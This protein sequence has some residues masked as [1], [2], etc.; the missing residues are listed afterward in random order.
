MTQTPRTEEARAIVAERIKAL[1]S[2]DGRKA[3]PSLT[4]PVLVLGAQ[5]DAIVP[6][7]LQQTLAD[8]LPHARL[9]IIESGGHFFPITRVQETVSLLT[10]FMDRHDG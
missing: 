9:A 2:F 1:L 5:D 3:A 8:A 7:P 6:L 4:M 10:A